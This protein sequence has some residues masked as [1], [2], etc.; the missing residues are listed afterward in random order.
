MDEQDRPSLQPVTD[1]VFAWV[2]PNGGKWVENAGAIVTADGVILID[3]GSTEPYAQGLLWAIAH[4]TSDA[5]VRY[6]VNT[7]RHSCVNNLLPDHAVI[8]GHTTCRAGWPTDLVTIENPPAV[9]S[10]LDEDAAWRPTTSSL[11]TARSSTRP[12]CLVCLTRTA[13]TTS[14]SSTRRRQVC[15]TGYRRLRRPAAVTLARSLTCPKLSGSSSTCTGPT[16]TSS[17][18]RLT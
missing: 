16:P 14:W 18:D 1:G 2:P 13:A 12:A 7:R 15:E 11:A 8:I 5:P 3:T 6:A 10:A 17:P 4:A 9:M